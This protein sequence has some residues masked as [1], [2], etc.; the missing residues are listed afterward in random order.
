MGYEIIGLWI[1]RFLAYLVASGFILA[2][3]Y[4]LIRIGEEERKEM[5][6]RWRQQ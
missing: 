1:L 4:F 2:T 6:G 5:E 3:G